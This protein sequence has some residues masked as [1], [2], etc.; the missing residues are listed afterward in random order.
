MVFERLDLSKWMVFR[1]AGHKV[2]E[3]MSKR[4]LGTVLCNFLPCRAS[5]NRAPARG[6][7]QGGGSENRK[8]RPSSGPGCEKNAMLDRPA[9]DFFWVLNCFAAVAKTLLLEGTASC[10]EFIFKPQ[11]HTLCMQSSS[12]KSNLSVGC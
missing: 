9:P 1:F 11:L 3:K 5:G 12:R 2:Q 4:V 8:H 10:Q 6:R 7:K